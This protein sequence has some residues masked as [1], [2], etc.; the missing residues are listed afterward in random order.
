MKLQRVASLAFLICLVLASTLS[1]QDEPVAIDTRQVVRLYSKDLPAE[2]NIQAYLKTGEVMLTNGLACSVPKIITGP[3]PAPYPQAVIWEKGIEQLGSTSTTCD[4][5]W[6]INGNLWQPNKIALIM[7]KIRIPQPSKRL[8]SEFDR[9]LTLSLWVDGNE[10]KAWGKNERVLDESFNIKKW[11]PNNWSYLEIW[12]LT[13]FRIPS[14]S[15]LGQ[16]CKDKTTKYETKLW[17][18]GAVSYDDADV[19]PAGEFLFGEVEDYQVEYFE[20]RHKDKE[21]G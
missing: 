11:F 6:F 5:M 17:I 20:I 21:K 9:D 15:G 2:V 3:A 1:A 18:R 8:A 7:W 4:G 12:Y 16:E 13:C 10:N 14:T 19:S